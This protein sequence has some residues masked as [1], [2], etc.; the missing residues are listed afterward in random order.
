MRI[1]GNV[2]AVTSI[3]TNDKRISHVDNINKAG[4]VQDAVKISDKGKD[5][6]VAQ[7]ALKNVPD[8]R[9]DKVDA[10]SAKLNNNDYS[11][12]G[13]DIIDKIFNSGIDT[14]A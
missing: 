6:T 8:I 13:E 11:I 1:D 9:Q 3:Y 7:K 12:K 10:I 14:E 2:N 4:Q 5:F